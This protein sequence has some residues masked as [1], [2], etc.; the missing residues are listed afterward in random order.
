[1]TRET[2]EETIKRRSENAE[3]AFGLLFDAYEWLW[4]IAGVFVG[5]VLLAIW[6]LG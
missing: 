4:I 3:A 2:E 1:M 6:L 5:L